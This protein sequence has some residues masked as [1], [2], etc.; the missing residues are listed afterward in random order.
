MGCS[1]SVDVRNTMMIDREC[2]RGVL[3]VVIESASLQ[4]ENDIPGK[5]DLYCKL[6][7]GDRLCAETRGKQGM[8]LKP[9]KITN[10]FH[11]VSEDSGQNPVWNETFELKRTHE[12]DCV[13][14]QVWNR[15]LIST[16]NY[17]GEGAF[18]LMEVY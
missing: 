13:L 17:I 7:F 2:W 8:I 18:S 16:D 4:V 12:E 14:L 11:L 6:F 10:K 1:A 15:N 3:N 9:K 5:I